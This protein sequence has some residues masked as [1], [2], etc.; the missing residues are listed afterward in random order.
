MKFVEALELANAAQS[1]E[2]F[3]MLAACGFTSLHLQTALKAHLRLTLLNRT[4]TIQAG[5]YGD[6]CGT[7]ESADGEWNAVIAVLE[8]ADIDPRLS[9]RTMRS[10]DDAVLTD[11]DARLQRLRSAIEAIARRGP[12]TVTLPVLP[13]SPVFHTVPGELHRIQA[14][15][16]EMVYRFAAEVPATIVHPASL[17]APAHDLR[18]ELLNGTPYPFAYLDA[19][20]ARLVRTLLPPAPKKG[21]I[22]DLDETLWAGVLGDD[23]PDGI[24]W[25][26]DHKTQFHGLYQELLNCLSEAGALIGVASKNDEALVRE[27]LTRRD[28]VVRPSILYPIEAHWQPKVE[29]IARTIEAWNIGSDSVVFVDDNPLEIEQI[30]TAFPAI[31]LLAFQKDD[32]GFLEALRQRFGK[33]AVREEDRLRSASLRNGKEIRQASAAGSS[34]DALLEG[35]QAKVTF[36]WLRQP[37]DARALELVNKTNQFNLNGR[38]FDAAD[39]NCMIS[40]PASHLIVA[41]YE[42][43]FG[44]LGKIAVMSGR[45]EDRVFRLGVW[46]MSCRAF[47]RRIEHQCLKL[48]FSRWN[49]IQMEFEPTQ[50]NGPLQNFLAQ[51]G[52]GAG[53]LDATHFQGCCP[54]LFHKTEILD[55]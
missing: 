44:K 6:V 35:A 51:I 14:R 52:A 25:D 22:T 18:A 38:R 42:D 17:P 32:A 28:L 10:V 33:R 23:G 26:L 2:P 20:A 13:Q 50:R 11:A 24:S 30:K 45:E 1:G 46:V 54:P 21:L 12:V 8:W 55:E 9:W 37:S 48:L 7:L 27:A 47:S 4:V 16:H 43:R 5:V 19:L 34:L 36:H 49:T 40:E 53:V 39:W 3:R 31:E 29:S 15:L 41:E